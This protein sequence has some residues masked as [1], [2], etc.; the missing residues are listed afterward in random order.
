MAGKNIKINMLGGSLPNM[1]DAL[2]GWEVSIVAD[3][4]RQIN[5]NNEI[6]NVTH[7]QRIAGVLQ[8]L[9]PEDVE[10][11][12]EGQRSWSWF[13]LHVKPHYRKLRVE[14]QIDIDKQPYKVMSVKDYQRY[15]YIEYHVIRSYNG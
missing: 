9:R 13:M 3:Y 10:L 12:P 1:N 4:I 2:N 5:S 6:K 7:T 11:K 14:Q 15:G 8:P